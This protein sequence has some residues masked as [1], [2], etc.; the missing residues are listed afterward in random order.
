MKEIQLGNVPKIYDKV[1]YADG[2]I[3]FA[4]NITSIPNHS[5]VFKVNFLPL[6]FVLKATFTSS[7]KITTAIS[8]PTTASLWTLMP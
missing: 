1:R 5:Q 4:D 7:T 6:S 2:E 3:F 8:L